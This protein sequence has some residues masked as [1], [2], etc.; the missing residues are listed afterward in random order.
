MITFTPPETKHYEEIVQLAA[1][2]AIDELGQWPTNLLYRMDCLVCFADKRRHDV[3]NVVKSV[4]DAL[5]EVAFDDDQ[6]VKVIHAISHLDR[7][8]PRVEVRISVV[9]QEQIDAL[10]SAW[11]S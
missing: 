6:Q 11:R 8:N 7:E 10:V 5:N 9:T 4:G 2:Q 1:E 3:D